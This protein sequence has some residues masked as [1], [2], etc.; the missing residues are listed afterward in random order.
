MEAIIEPD[1]GVIY[2]DRA[3]KAF[4]SIAEMH[5]AKVFSQCELLSWNA[6]PGR[7]DLETAKGGFTADNLILTPGAWAANLLGGIGRLVRPVVKSLYWM[8]AING[9]PSTK[10]SFPS[11]LSNPTAVFSMDFL[12]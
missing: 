1:A 12:Q 7:I 4:I 11:A 8:R 9:F 3:L 5:G 10:G 6:K 2:A